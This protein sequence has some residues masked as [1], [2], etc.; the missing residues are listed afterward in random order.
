MILQL[1][2]VHIKYT[3]IWENIKVNVYIELDRFRIAYMYYKLRE[4]SLI[5]N[6]GIRFMGGLTYYHVSKDQLYFTFTLG[7]KHF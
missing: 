5:M 4:C 7:F 1:Q 2:Y 3:Q 6:G